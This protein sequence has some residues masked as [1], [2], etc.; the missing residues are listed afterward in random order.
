MQVKE[1][2]YIII[3]KYRFLYFY[4][5]NINYMKRLQF[6]ATSCYLQ[7]FY[8]WKLSF[9]VVCGC[10]HTTCFKNFCT[11]RFFLKFKGAITVAKSYE[12]KLLAYISLFYWYYN[13]S[14]FD[15]LVFLENQ[16]LFSKVK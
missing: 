8:S 10:P 12:K 13:K 1:I 3:C 4:K 15:S 9:Y 16:L 6:Y 5:F 14:Y 2:F 7:M 11:S